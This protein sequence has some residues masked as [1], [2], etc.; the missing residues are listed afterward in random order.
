MSEG[1]NIKGGREKN[2]MIVIGLFILL[3]AVA[4]PS[5]HATSALLTRTTSLILISAAFLVANV[6]SWTGLGTGLSLYGGLINVTGVAITSQV[7]LLVVGALA[8]TP[9]APQGTQGMTSLPRVG[10]YPLFALITTIGGCMLVSSGDVITFYLSLELQSFSVYVLAALYRDSESA[11][12]AGL[13]Y[14]LLGGLSSSLILLG[15]A[16][17]YSQTGIT[18]IDGLMILLGVESDTISWGTLLGFMSVLTGLLFKITAAPFHH[19]GPDVYDG[20]PTIVTT[21]LAVLPK[22]SLIMFLLTLSNGLNGALQVFT[23]TGSSYDVWTTLLQVSCVLSLVIGTVVGLAQS[24]IKRLLAYSTVS[25]MGFMLAAMSLSTSE[26]T[27]ATILYLVQYTLTALLSFSAVLALGYNRQVKRE[28]LDLID[29][30]ELVGSFKKN[31]AVSTCLATSLFSMAGVPP[32]L[33]FYGKQAV[34]SASLN[35]GLVFISIV[36][37]VTSVISASYYLYL[38]RVSHFDTEEK[39]ITEFTHTVN[40]NTSGQVTSLHSYGLSV[41][42]LMTIGFMACPDLLLDTCRL[43]AITLTTV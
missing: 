24:R 41:M 33:G 4:L 14:F 43:M 27:A 31:P 10:T 9:W 19:W 22:I 38:V 25:H 34:L 5:I 26:G 39:N 30:S 15:F 18:S 12:H 13:L 36:A 17:V 6:Y 1:V 29:I 8:L 16:L 28:S 32:L 37:V 2:E 21:W 11:T 3:T 35:G 23:G 42:T 7:M 20:V 40:Q